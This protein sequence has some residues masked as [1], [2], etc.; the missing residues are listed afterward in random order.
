[1]RLGVLGVG[2]LARAIL[3]GLDR[4]G[5]DPSQVILSPRGHGPEL[6]AAQGYGLAAD[7]V[8][9]VARADV[10]LLAVRPAAAASA[11]TGLPWRA[12]QVLLSACAGVSADTLSSVAP[13][14]RVVR[15]M[16]MT[17]AEIGR[18]PTTIFPDDPVARGWIEK[19]GPVVPLAREQDF[20]VATVSAAVYGWAQ[21]LIART[22]DWSAAQGL[23][24][25]TARLLVARTF[26]GAGALIAEKPEPMP[27]L[28]EELV[29]PGG[30]TERGLQVL[31]GAG[32]PAAWDAACQA[33]LDKLRDQRPGGSP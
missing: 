23:D 21:D 5:V 7:N 9:L 22:A 32:L 1:M 6:A 29:T 13:G 25:A 30:I 11:V 15:I 33:V 4:A 10:V 3:K 27:Q 26:E 31:G 2:H 14:A 24:A 16:P 17:A 12:G 28:L 18:S 20:E 8:E 19:L